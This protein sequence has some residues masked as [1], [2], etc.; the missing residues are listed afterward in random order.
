MTNPLPLNWR[1]PLLHFALFIGGIYLYAL[2]MELWGGFSTHLIYLQWQEFVLVL[3]LYG[4]IYG[5][6]KPSVWR[7]WLAAVPIFAVYLVHDIFY[8]VYGK[9]FRFVNVAEVP[10]LLQILPPGYAVLLVIGFLTPF[11]LILARIDY[12]KP[13]RI[14]LGLLPLVL[15]VTLIKAT[16]VA[17]AT[18]FKSVAHEIVKYSDGKSVETNGRLAMLLFREAEREGTLKAIEPYLNRAGF[19]KAFAREVA[20]IR[21]YLKPRNVHLIVLESFLDPRLFRDLKLSRDPVHPD[22]AALF[23][24]KLGL[25]TSPV[26]GGATSQAEFEVLCGVPALE[27]L[28]SVEFNTFT[29]AQ[30]HC[31]PGL[32]GELGYR[33]IASNAYK[34]NF[35][36]TQPAYKGMGFAEQQ[37]PVEFFTLEPTYLKFG[38]PGAEEYLFDGDLFPQNLDLVRRHLEEHPNQPLF[39]YLL[40]IYGHTPHNL[41]E[42]KRPILIKSESNNSDDQVERVVN[43]FYYRTQ[44]IA[45]YVREL[46]ALD[47][48][49]LIVLVSDHVPPLQFGPLTYKALAYMD[50]QEGSYFYNRL[51]ILEQGKPVTYDPMRHFDLPKLIMNNLTQGHYC[52]T[53]DC[54]YLVKTKPPRDAYYDKYLALMAHASE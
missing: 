5:L 12:G 27:R 54:D 14:I 51:A 16:P 24:N 15:V 20:G 23:G 48:D 3:Y 4:L 25:S 45:N 39:N 9:V 46:I 28:S 52:A 34:P 31:L 53:G 21:P 49:G 11:A 1:K 42:D 8:L 50:N 13:L 18:G 33:A 47:P 19:D 17:F 44:A 2:L 10:E 36:N 35:F 29:G 22:F 40:T 41:N 43:Q 30:A 38:D 7:P 32:L 26:F 6:L 37:F